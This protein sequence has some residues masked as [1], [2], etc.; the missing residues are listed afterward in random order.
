[1]VK[2]TVISPKF[3]WGSCVQPYSLAETPQLPPPLPPHLGSYTRAP[4]VSQDRRNLFVTPLPLPSTYHVPVFSSITLVSI[5]HSLSLLFHS[6]LLFSVLFPFP[7][8]VG[9]GGGGGGIGY[10]G[11]PV[12]NHNNHYI[13]SNTRCRSS[14][15]NSPLTHTHTLPFT[16]HY[17]FSLQLYIIGV[18]NGLS[19]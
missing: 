13:P 15:Q 12:A 14:T 17:F 6:F 11:R 8:S 7:S 18:F 1:L 9:V 16:N 4:L 19:A 10:Q 3:I 5:A 2:Y